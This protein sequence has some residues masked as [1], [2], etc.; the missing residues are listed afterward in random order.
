[1]CLLI[2]IINLTVRT[3]EVVLYAGSYTHQFR[4]ILK[5]YTAAHNVVLIY[6]KGKVHYKDDQSKV[7]QI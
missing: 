6:Y 3:E 4:H 5:Q 1:L 2:G 7:A